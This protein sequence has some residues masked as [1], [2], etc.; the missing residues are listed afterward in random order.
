MAEQLDLFAAAADPRPPRPP[1][2]DQSAR[3]LV[4]DALGTTLFV[5]AGAGSGKTTALV[6]RVVNLV[7]G[8]VPIGSIAAITFTEKAAA[9]L[10]HRIREALTH[11]AGS[12]AGAQEA[13]QQAL[14]DLDHAPIGTLHAFAQRLLNEFPVEAGLP[15]RFDVLDEV[16]SA[17]AFQERFTDFIEKLLDDPASTRLVELCQFDGFNV[18]RD[19]R[20]MADDFQANWDLV[21]E[22]VD[23]DPPAPTAIDVDKFVGL[24]RDIAS[25]DAPPGD[26]QQA[27]IAEASSIAEALAA[28]T[29]LGEQLL[30]LDSMRAW[31]PNGGDATKWR[32]HTGGGSALPA[33]RERITAA[34]EAAKAQ[35]SAYIDERRRTLGALLRE[36]TLTSVAERRA[37][38]ELEFHDLLVFARRLVAGNDSVRAAF[39]RRYTHL[40]LDEFQDTDPIQLELAV[41][42]TAPPDATA[43]DWR[44]LRPEP[45]LLC[46]VGD[47][48]QSIYRFRRADIGQ[49]LR[50]REQLGATRAVLS[51]NFRTAEPVVAWI[52]H[53][54]SRLI[55]ADGEVQPDYVPLVACRPGPHHHGTVTVLGAEPHADLPRAAAEE[56]RAREAADVAAVVV[57]A[58]TEGWPVVDTSGPE[59]VLRACRAS[60]IAILLPARTSLPALQSALAE[61]HIA[62][63]AENSSLVY[64]APEVRA[65]LLALRAADDPTDELA[66]VSVLRTPLFGCSDRHLY[67]W[68][69]TRGLPWRAPADPP[70]SEGGDTSSEIDDHPVAVGLRTLRDLS[71][72]IALHTPSELL[73]H[74]I[75]QRCSFEVAL[76]GSDS[77]D[78]WRRLRFVVDQA[79]AWSESGGHGIRRYL[80]WTRLQGDEGRFV[81][82]TV[83]PE[84]DH[85]A[86]RVLT[87]HAAKGLEF[88]ITI[89][90]GL[91]SQPRAGRGRRVVWPPGTWTLSERDDALYQEFMPVDEQMG[92]AER[93]RLLYVATTRAQ[94]H[95]VVSLHRGA[96][97]DHTAA[98]RLATAS[99]GATHLASSGTEEALLATPPDVAELPW[100]DQREWADALGG[101]LR[102]AARRSVLSATGLAAQFAADPALQ[103]D[104][105]D[106]DLPPW[107]RGRYGTA[108]GRAVHAVLQHTAFPAVDDITNLATAQAAAEGVLGHEHTIAA[109]ARSA[110]STDIVRA[111]IGHEHWRELFV[112]TQIGDTVVEGYIDL[113]VRHPQRGLVVVD[114]KTD[115]LAAVPDREQRLLRY[116]VQLAAYAVALEQLLGEPIAAGVLVLCTAAGDARASEHEIA[117]WGDLKQSLRASLVGDA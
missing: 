2:P 54:M 4:A 20:Q 19:V 96:S 15:P 101:H 36:F 104:A 53:T 14:D 108:I 22:R 94:D 23:P 91:T 44:E 111:A 9:E 86:V 42:I 46:V 110:L 102:H 33:Y 21:D 64:A 70:T 30:L 117:G 80:M 65:L 105:V 69:V 77:R 78:V 38:G 116:G 72:M 97:P 87:V 98:W 60:D 16:Q 51:A 67:D 114:Y 39:H 66:I 8:E 63:R 41:R 13:A 99:E 48:K 113:L 55:V 107:Q 82:E 61:R 95:L 18:E 6:S 88:P 56:L 106:I 58:I 7:L 45:G 1:A 47:P 12:S 25:F 27:R 73:T 68:R 49:F 43:G 3:D 34:A 83:L 109:L 115:Q 28:S 100:A 103:K 17:T 112:A 59:P 10:R 74:L 90:S 85:D 75:E 93:K 62:Y 92:D 57:Q 24:C 52:N 89:V 84:A 81:A 11:L 32:R 79:R 76:A 50:S 35:I 37:A 5:E 29:T 26:T 40:L 31:K 71:A